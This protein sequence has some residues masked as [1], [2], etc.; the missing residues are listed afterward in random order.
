MDTNKKKRKKKAD[1]ANVLVG[2]PAANDKSDK[3]KGEQDNEGLKC[4]DIELG[5]LDSA[6]G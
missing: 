4:D 1:F 5:V 6:R 3:R 2:I